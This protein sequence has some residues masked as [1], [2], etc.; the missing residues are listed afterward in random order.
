MCTKS[1]TTLLQTV[2]ARPYL[3][4]RKGDY[5]LRM[6]PVGSTKKLFTVSLRTHEKP[7]A[8][9][10]TKYILAALAVFH[11]DSREA[12]WADLHGRLSHLAR[13]ALEVAHTDKSLVAYEVVY[14]DL[15]NCISTGVATM[16]LT[17]NQY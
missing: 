1:G 3:Y 10:L 7:Q 15:S 14:T 6:R 5:Y 4:R 2:L 12:S 17:L 11:L 9:E 8:T 16:P 13:E